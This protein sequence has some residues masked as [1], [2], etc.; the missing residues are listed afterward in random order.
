[1][2]IHKKNDNYQGAISLK[3]PRTDMSLWY[4]N[5][6]MV[7]QNTVLKVQWMHLA[8]LLRQPLLVFWFLCICY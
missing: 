4:D 3:C 1:M 7:E 6:P 5:W 2:K 8:L